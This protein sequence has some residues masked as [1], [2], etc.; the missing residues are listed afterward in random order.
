MEFKNVL[1]YIRRNKS[2]NNMIIDFVEKE[3]N[4]NQYKT[5]SEYFNAD[6]R[7]DLNQALCHIQLES[8]LG[9]NFNLESVVFRDRVL[10][11]LT[12]KRALDLIKI[13]VSEIDKVLSSSDFDLLV[14][15]PVDNYI[16]DLLVCMAKRRGMKVLG[17]S[18]FFIGGYKRVTVYGE[19]NDWR[20]PDN[21]EVEGVLTKLKSNFKSH[22]VP[23]FRKA[24]K[25]AVV[26]YVKYKLRYLIFY[27]IGNKVLRR[28]EYDLLATP[29][30]ATVRNLLNFFAPCFFDK[31]I[32]LQG[33][34]VLVPLHYYPEA[35]LEYWGGSQY[36]IEYGPHVLDLVT[37]LSKEYETVVV[38]E[39]P[40]MVFNNNLSF[41]RELKKIPNVALIDPFISTNHL[42]EK[43][44]NLA[45]WTGSAGV[46]ALINGKNVT[47]YSDNYYLQAGQTS[48]SL[49][50]TS[51]VRVKDESAF[52]K[53][54][55]KGTYRC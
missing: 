35:T 25:D 50:G 55:L 53:E 19:H 42:L 40:A 17:I 39:H 52:L 21:S 29:Y 28:N 49:T 27:L 10:R 37:S 11:N 22:M 47:F 13:A 32:D 14:T 30:N 41:Y 38:K 26:R 2:F 34:T 48:N 9:T 15:Y 6:Y 12:F 4:I 24:V 45:C 43:V 31:N 54:V 5:V 46:E 23:S 8:F 16:T 7:V 44:D 20:E 36:A 1:V 3:L 51:Q 18:N 33:D